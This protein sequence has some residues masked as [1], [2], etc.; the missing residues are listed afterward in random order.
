MKLTQSLQ[1]I[2]SISFI[3]CLFLQFSCHPNKVKDADRG[4]YY[5]IVFDAS[6]KSAQFSSTYFSGCDAKTLDEKTKDYAIKND[7]A[8]FKVVGPYVK[9]D[10]ADDDKKA[11]KD[12]YKE[13]GYDIGGDNNFFGDCYP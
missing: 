9:S 11:N 3:S 5:S 13:S 4:Y 8:D 7:Y 10:D 1:K 6:K 12:R 2:L